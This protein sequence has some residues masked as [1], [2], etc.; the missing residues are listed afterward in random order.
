MM[1]SRDLIRRGIAIT[2]VLACIWLLVRT[3]FLRNAP[4]SIFQNAEEVEFYCMFALTCPLC[5]VG[6]LLARYV[7]FGW[8]IYPENDARTILAIWLY[9]FVIGSIQWFVLVPGLIQKGFEVYDRILLLIR[10]KQ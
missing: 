1:Q 2:W 5:G 7:G 4:V 9:F 6:L 3:L 10:K 8:W